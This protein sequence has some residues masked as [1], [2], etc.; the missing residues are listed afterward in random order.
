M[1]IAKTTPRHKTP[2]IHKTTI[3]IDAIFC[4]GFDASAVM[5]RATSDINV[6]NSAIWRCVLALAA[7]ALSSRAAKAVI[8]AAL[9]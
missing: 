3:L 4:A 7:T 5:V 1:G 6:I 9:A 8:C 2:N